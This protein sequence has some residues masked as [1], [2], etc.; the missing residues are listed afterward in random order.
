MASSFSL[1]VII[2]KE[3]QKKTSTHHDGNTTRNQQTSSHNDK[4]SLHN[5]KTTPHHNVATVHYD[6]TP[7][8]LD[9]ISR[10]KE[11]RLNKKV[12]ASIICYL[13]PTISQG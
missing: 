11:Q 12:M 13:F 5:D 8:H 9:K 6:K 10:P 3:R 7:K 2:N 1:Y 4:T